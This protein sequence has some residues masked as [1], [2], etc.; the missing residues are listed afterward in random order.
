MDRGFSIGHIFGINIRVDWS[1]LFIFVLVVWN[2]SVV[3]GGVH[4]E[5]GAALIWGM[6]VVAAL[7]FFGSVLAHELA[8]SLVAQARGIPVRHIT[9]FLFGGVANIQK[10]P[11][12][13]GAEFIMAIVGPLTSVVLGGLLLVVGVASAGPVPDVATS[14][15]QFLASLGPLTTLLL[16]LGSVNIIVG[17]FN[18]L[19]AFPLDGGRVLRSFFW[20][21]VGD[22]R[23]ATR[24]AS[25]IGQAI[26][27]LMILVGIGMVFGLQFPILGSGPINGVWLAFI[28]WFL[29]SSASRSYQQVVVQDMLG[30]VPVRRIMRTNPPTVPPN[31]SIASLV[32]EYVMGTDDHSFPVVEG[33]RLV[34]MICLHDVRDV[35]RAEWE[36]TLVR[37]AMTPEGS[38]ITAKPEEDAAEALERLQQQDV[39]QLP[40][41]R[42]GTLEGLLRRRDIV[43]WLQLESELGARTR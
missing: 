31:I 38:L 43:R 6:A 17:L 1:W 26:A 33:D 20:A 28:G 8:H 15:N 11:T 9:L 7:L 30:G 39:R 12:S 29:N 21:A 24:W 32:H 4:P 19:P 2:L 41:T 36:T 27:W 13:A 35:P 25:W 40:V 5:W 42:N 37:E 3:F 10:E 34:G 22:L 14:P 18:M 23:R 16:W